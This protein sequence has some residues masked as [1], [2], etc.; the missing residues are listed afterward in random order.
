MK[1]EIE[2]EVTGGLTRKQAGL[3]TSLMVRPFLAASL[4]ALLDV[5]VHFHF[6]LET[7][8]CCETMHANASFVQTSGHDEHT[9]PV[10]FIPA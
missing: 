9:S 4:H 1:S 3:L 2:I 8:S 10:C 5:D 6:A 7:S